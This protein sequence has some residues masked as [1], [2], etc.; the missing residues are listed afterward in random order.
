MKMTSKMK[1][2]SEIKRTYNMKMTSKIKTTSKMK[3]TAK[4][5][6]GGGLSFQTIFPAP[7]TSKSCKMHSSIADWNYSG[8]GRFGWVQ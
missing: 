8:S 5:L 3:T 6:R 1:T 4:M 2:T 7:D